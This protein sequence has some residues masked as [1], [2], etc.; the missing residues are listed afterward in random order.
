MRVEEL[1]RDDL[2][3]LAAYAA[4]LFVAGAAGYVTAEV[5]AARRTFNLRGRLPAR[6][7]SSGF[8]LTGFLQAIAGGVRAAFLSRGSIPDA[9]RIGEGLS[10]PPATGRGAA[11]E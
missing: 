11:E 7:F 6:Y 9:F 5:A 1:V 2:P 3:W 4:V 8:Y 10:S